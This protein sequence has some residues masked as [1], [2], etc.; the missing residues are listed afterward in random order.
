MNEQDKK[1][2]Y[3]ERFL[4]NDYGTF[5]PPVFF[6]FVEVWRGNAVH[7]IQDYPIYCRR[8]VIYQNR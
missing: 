1:R 6:Q 3:N 5:T 7:F 2:T 8:N 4:Q